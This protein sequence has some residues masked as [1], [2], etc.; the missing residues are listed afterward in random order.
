MP[1]PN[2]LLSVLLILLL[3]LIAL[4]RAGAAEPALSP[5]PVPQASAAPETE[6]FYNSVLAARDAATLR[7]YLNCLSQEHL[8]ELWQTLDPTRQ[9][10]LQR[11]MEELGVEPPLSDSTTQADLP[12]GEMVLEPQ[13]GYDLQTDTYTVTFEAW[14]TGS[15]ADGQAPDEKAVLRACFSDEFSLQEAQ[16]RLWRVEKTAAGW[17][18]TKCGDPQLQ[19]TLDP[20]LKT[21]TVTGFDYTANYVCERPRKEGTETT[22]GSKLV[23]QVVGLKADDQATFG[24]QGIPLCRTAEIYTDQTAQEPCAVA[25]DALVDLPIRY[26]YMPADQT[27]LS[28]Q[29]VN[30]G[31]MIRPTDAQTIW[32]DGSNNAWVDLEYAVELEG[33]TLCRYVVP[34]GTAMSQGRWDPAAPVQTLTRDTDYTVVLTMTAACPGAGVGPAR[35]TACRRQATVVRAMV[36]HF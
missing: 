2:R 1:K 31:Y 20:A 4:V 30:F 16:V 26:L 6:A 14:S 17:A 25:K 18:Q 24:G 13:A 33:E 15:A 9:A 27:V 21:L 7:A 10:R 34:H 36:P 35:E 29:A 32:P 3:A 28:G 19:A 22:L 23:V 8:Q 5:T 11:A 12:K